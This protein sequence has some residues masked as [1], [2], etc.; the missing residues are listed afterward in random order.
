MRVRNRKR[1]CVIVTMTSWKCS[2]PEGRP[3]S[4]LFCFLFVAASF[5]HARKLTLSLTYRSIEWVREVRNNVS[6]R[7]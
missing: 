3:S 6:L 4:L 7:A 1:R 5:T 2:A